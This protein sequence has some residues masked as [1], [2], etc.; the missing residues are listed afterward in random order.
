MVI[1]LML[2]RDADDR[3]DR[4]DVADA[5]GEEPV[6]GAV[7]QPALDGRQVR[8]AAWRRGRAR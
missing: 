1:A 3:E 6:G 7:D 5:E 2:R 8:T 4:D